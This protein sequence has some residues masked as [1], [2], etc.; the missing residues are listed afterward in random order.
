MMRHAWWLIKES[1]EFF[2]W[3]LIRLD[4][5]LNQVQKIEHENKFSLWLFRTFAQVIVNFTSILLNIYVTSYCLCSL[6]IENVT[7]TFNV[8]H[9]PKLDFIYRVIDWNRTLEIFNFMSLSSIF[10]Q[11]STN[12]YEENVFSKIYPTI[13][14]NNI[15]FKFL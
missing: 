12:L 4:H 3:R 13:L 2:D 10:N 5:I 7:D 8:F 14:E 15:K 6:L 1:W 9:R 11:S